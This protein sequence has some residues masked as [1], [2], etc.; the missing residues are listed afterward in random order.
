MGYAS[1]EEALEA[2]RQASAADDPFHFALL[3]Y[4]MPGMDGTTLAWAIKADRAIRDTVLILLTSVDHWNSAGPMDEAVISAALVKPVRQSQLLNTLATA[5][6]RRLREPEPPR[7][8]EDMRAVL[9]RRFS[10]ALVRVLVAED[11][12]VNQKVASRML[13]KLGL[14]ADV[15]ANGREAVAMFELLPYDFIF[16]DCQMPEMDGY[17]A[18]RAIRQIEASE[19]RVAIVAMTADALAGCREVCLSAGMDDYIAKPVTVEVVF[20]AL[21]RWIPVRAANSVQLLSGG[22]A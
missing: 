4:H 17:E 19:R 12:V 10:G 6:S 11:N 3:D 2:I 16:M 9:Q 22:S 5:W 14:R 20:E 15:A 21:R 8:M 18:T 7:R 1:G 13:E